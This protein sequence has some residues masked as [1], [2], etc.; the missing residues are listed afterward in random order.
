MALNPSVTVLGLFCADLISRTP[1]LPA[2]GETLHGRGFSLMAGGKGSNQAVAA[3]RQGAS[4]A[5]ISR[6]GDDAFAP[7]ARSLY[8]EAGIDMTHVGTD[9]AAPTGTATILVDDEMGDNAIV[10]DPG[11]CQNLTKA[12]IDAAQSVIA[13]S[14]IFV[15]Q[16]E[17]PLEIC[18]Y[19]IET[20]H[21]HGVPVILNPAPGQVIPEAMYPLIDYL[22]PNESEAA[23]LVGGT[24]ETL[25]DARDA[26]SILRKRGVGHV[27]I[28]LGAQG[29]WIDSPSF[30]G[31]VPAI[32][33]DSVVDTIGA[34][35]AFNGGLAAALAE[36]A[37][38]EA[39]AR[40]GCAIAGLSVA[41]AGAA[42]AIPMREV[43]DA[44]LMRRNNEKGCAD[45]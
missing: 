24:V 3:A 25:D 41:R 21:Q 6:L 31:L 35:D 33:V 34:G 7:L 20:A 27:L 4:V 43:V 23:L 1:R 37:T 44:E 9:P 30:E 40:R 38:L 2:W 12:D 10:I 22:T 26:A 45:Q 13:G 42:P 14:A 11:A 8:A 16:L 18:R 5:F 36:G 32:R 29:V 19:G 39:A 17:L 15:S 28:T